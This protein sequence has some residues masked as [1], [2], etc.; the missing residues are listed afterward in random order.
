MGWI[1]GAHVLIDLVEENVN[2]TLTCIG[3][4]P[5]DCGYSQLRTSL[6]DLYGF[7]QSCW[8]NSKMLS[9]QQ[10][11]SAACLS[12]SANLGS[13]HMQ[14]CVFAFQYVVLHGTIATLVIAA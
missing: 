11:R 10:L 12:Q 9:P 5:R 7:F 8:R 3:I 13:R 4:A 2:R 14:Q 1:Y 6:A